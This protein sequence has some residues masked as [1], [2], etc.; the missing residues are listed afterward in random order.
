MT[1]EEKRELDERLSFCYPYEKAVR[2]Y[3]KI[4]VSDLKKQ[5]M[6]EADGAELFP[7]NDGQPAGDA[8]Q[9]GAG[10]TAAK[11]PGGADRGTAYHRFL[12]C[13]DFTKADSAEAV[14]LAGKA[15][16]EAGKMTEAEAACVKAEEIFRF[17]Q[18]ALG[19]R[20]TRAAQENQ[21]KKESRFVMGIPASECGLGAEP[22]ETLLIQGVMDACFREEEAWVLVEYK[23][24]R[25]PFR[26]GEEIL[27]ERY[28]VQLDTYERAL[29]QMTG[30]PVK[31]SWIYSFALGRA[32]R[33]DQK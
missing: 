18:S 29:A 13:L 32:F 1:E 24:D 30:E 22:D 27:R 19:R 23:T 11:E 7:K 26:G 15:M 6:E 16:A 10:N 8:A 17:L 28:Q 5:G 25:V 4:S 2:M 21:L 9:P 31:E 3:R 14:R 20:M 12:E 33:T